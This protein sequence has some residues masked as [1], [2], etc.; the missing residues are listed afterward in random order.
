MIYKHQVGERECVFCGTVRKST[1]SF[2]PDEDRPFTR[3]SVGPVCGSPCWAQ[4]LDIDPTT[5]EVRC[6]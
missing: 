3:G 1:F 5:V 2:S 4:L 6:V